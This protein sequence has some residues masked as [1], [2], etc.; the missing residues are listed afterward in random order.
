MLTASQL[1]EWE[2][3][4]EFDPIGSFRADYNAAL[5][6]STLIN[7]AQAANKRSK[8]AKPED[9]MPKWGVEEPKKQSLDDMK[10]ALYAMVGKNYG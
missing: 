3:Y 7:I 2:E 8:P 1:A 9:F 10:K 6:C 5:I 4:Q